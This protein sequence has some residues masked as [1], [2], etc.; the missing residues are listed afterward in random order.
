MGKDLD[1]T[2]LK[3]SVQALRNGVNVYNNYIASDSAVQDVSEI[4][5]SG[6]IHNF[7]VAYEVCWKIMQK[8]IDINIGPNVVKGVIKKAFYR[9]AFDNML[10]DDIDAWM[11]FNETRNSTAHIYEETIANNVLKEIF[12]FLIYAEKFVETMEGKI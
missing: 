4:L 7:E 9:V 10:I 8:W 2:G 11:S 12:K 1:I 6:V 5:R 3:G